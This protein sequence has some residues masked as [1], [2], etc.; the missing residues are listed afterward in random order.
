MAE[1]KKE[2]KK[3]PAKKAEAKESAKGMYKYL[4]KA[5]KKPD[6][7]MLRKSMIEWRKGKRIEKIKKPTRLDRA[8]SLGY[9]AKKG[10]VILRVQILRGGRKR[11]V[12]NKKRRTKRQSVKKIL[13]MN[14]KWVAEQRCQR[15][16][17]NLEVLNSYPLAK[18]GKYYFFE[19]I[20][21]DPSRPE[22]K[23]DPNFKWIT[24]KK[25]QKRA[26]RG[27]TSSA[28]KSRGLRNRSKN[29]KVRPSL[30][31]WKRRGK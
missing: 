27:L 16:Y 2:P 22:I 3:K 12:P 24:S 17:K 8:R 29:L 30:R 21:I 13:K 5:W 25:N 11:S 10:F 31:A 23:K 18:D 6:Q 28:K 26:I 20:M 14:Y 15:K 1:A 19:V 4:A 9:K 7:E